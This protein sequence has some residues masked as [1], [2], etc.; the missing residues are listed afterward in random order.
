MKPTILK[1]NAPSRLWRAT[2]RKRYVYP[3][4]IVPGNHADLERPECG[5]NVAIKTPETIKN[6]RRVTEG[7]FIYCREIPKPS[8]SKYSPHLG[9]KELNRIFK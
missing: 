4:S 7:T 2:R 5:R 8:R 1:P 3:K 6:G 9:K